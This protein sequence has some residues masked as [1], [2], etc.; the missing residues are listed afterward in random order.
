MA[1]QFT[2]DEANALLPSIVPQLETLR[3]L[4]RR[5]TAVREQLDALGPQARGNGQATVAMRLEIESAD[6]M[7]KAEGLLRGLL[8]LGVEVK[9]PMQGLIDFRSLRDGREVYLCWR[10]GEGQLAYW[11][12]LDAGFQ[13]R[14]PL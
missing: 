6:L 3:D 14:R 9:D 2:V 5:L 1:R 10:L 11:H 13:G 4:V 8:D 12:E 7:A